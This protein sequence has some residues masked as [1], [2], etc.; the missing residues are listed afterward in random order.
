MENPEIWIRTICKKNGLFVDDRTLSLLS[1]YVKLLLEWNQKINLISRKDEANVWENH[2]LHCVS[3]LFKVRFAEGANM[4]DLGTGGGL[5][6]IPLG[7]LCPTLSM[8]LL[9]A[10]QKKVNA[11]RDMVN[12]LGLRNVEVYWSRAE[13][14]ARNSMFQK[15]FDYVVARAVAPLRDLFR[16]SL[17]LLVPESRKER[18]WGIGSPEAARV[19]PPALVTLKGGNLEK[20]IHELERESHRQSVVVT[21]LVFEGSEL[22]GA[23]DKKIVVVNPERG[24]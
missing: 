16:W 23:S 2:I 24:T 5:P 14:V 1:D 15:K 17:P 18:S 20:E 13:D 6:G 12:R 22:V 11:V 21:N 4:L 10:T 9:D 19:I 7:I 3:L 8:T